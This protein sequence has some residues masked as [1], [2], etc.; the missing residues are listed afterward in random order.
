MNGLFFTC[1]CHHHRKR[2]LYIYLTPIVGGFRVLY[3]D[4]ENIETGCPFHMVEYIDRYGRPVGTAHTTKNTRH[5]KKTFNSKLFLI[6][7]LRVP[8]T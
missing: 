1:Y 4:S 5:I 3:T 7:L 6:G 2:K 8:I